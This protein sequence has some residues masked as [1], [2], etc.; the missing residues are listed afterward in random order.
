MIHFNGVMDVSKAGGSVKNNNV[1]K[2]PKLTIVAD[3]EEKFA[4]VM[5]KLT[6][7]KGRT[8]L[9][10]PDGYDVEEI[11]RGVGHGDSGNEN[12][13]GHDNTKDL[14]TSVKDHQ[15]EFI[16]NHRRN[17][18]RSYRLAVDCLNDIT[19]RNST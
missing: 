11:F 12:V 14:L 6:E 19:S 10:N 18:N 1:R 16:N 2:K 8:N 9:S 4:F 3:N 7:A 5:R 17:P 15:H 13:I